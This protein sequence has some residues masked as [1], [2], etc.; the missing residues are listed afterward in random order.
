MKTFIYKKTEFG[1]L[2]HGE[3]LTERQSLLR[4]GHPWGFAGFK[5]LQNHLLALEG[6]DPAWKGSRKLWIR[7]LVPHINNM[8][9]KKG[10]LGIFDLFNY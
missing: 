4:W 2:K 5:P 1:W 7:L 3:E 9:S 6:T 8:P 10:P